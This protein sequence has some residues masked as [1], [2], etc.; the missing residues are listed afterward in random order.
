MVTADF[1]IF[2][3]DSVREVKK[4]LV[5]MIDI[6]RCLHFNYIVLDPYGLYIAPQAHKHIEIGE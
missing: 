5:L 4:F 6:G 3:S 1:T 2:L